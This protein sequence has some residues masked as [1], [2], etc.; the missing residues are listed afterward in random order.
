MSLDVVAWH[1]MVLNGMGASYPLKNQR[2][3]S[4]DPFQNPLLGLWMP[5]LVLYGMRELALQHYGPLVLVGTR[6]IRMENTG[7]AGLD[8][9]HH[10]PTPGFGSPA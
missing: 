1:Q 3:E 2:G 9:N 7:V 5:E 4:K 6:A 10:N 8:N